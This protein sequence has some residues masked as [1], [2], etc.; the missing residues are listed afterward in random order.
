MI[1]LK[2]AGKIEEGLI[3]SKASKAW[4]KAVCYIY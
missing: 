4:E 2:L 1:N 3:W